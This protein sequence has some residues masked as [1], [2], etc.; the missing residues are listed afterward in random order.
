MIRPAER[1]DMAELTALRTS[2]VENHLGVDEMAV[3]GITPETVLASV[4]A[5]E[6]CCFVAEEDGVIAGFSMADRRDGQIFALFTRPGH[7]GRGHGSRLLGE[8][9]D[10]LIAHGHAAA[11]LT[12]APGTR[13]ERFYR[14]KGWQPDGQTAEG[15]VVLRL[16]SIPRSRP[17]RSLNP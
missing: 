11:W 10:W 5:G 2:V 1:G 9:L 13:A 16:N 17:A 15:D 8:A 12:T 14:L 7:E 3:M 6:R 4:E